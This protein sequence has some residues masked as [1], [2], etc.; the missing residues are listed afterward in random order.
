MIIEP[1]MSCQCSICGQGLSKYK[2]PTCCLPYCSLSCWKNHKSKECVPPATNGYI[3]EEK[4]CPKKYEFET[5]DTVPVEKLALLENDEALRQILENPHV[6]NILLNVDSARDPSRAIQEAMLE[7]IFVEF[8]DCC[9]KVVEPP[10]E[11]D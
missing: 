7:P 10:T 5:E 4:I 8:A 9:L 6:R 1:K 3:E 2:C 11:G